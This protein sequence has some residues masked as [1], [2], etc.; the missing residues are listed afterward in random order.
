MY[1]REEEYKCKSRKQDCSKLSKPDVK[2]SQQQDHQ[3]ICPVALSTAPHL[4]F[5]QV[6]IIVTINL[7]ENVHRR[8]G[9]TDRDEVDLE[10][11][12]CI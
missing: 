2:H 12:P 6:I 10:H 7:L 11:Q 8:G 9:V 3:R 4:F 1:V 5:G